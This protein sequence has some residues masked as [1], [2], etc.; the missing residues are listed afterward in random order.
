MQATTKTKM[1]AEPKQLKPVADAHRK[2]QLDFTIKYIECDLADKRVECK[3]LVH[4]FFS[5]QFVRDEE[6]GGIVVIRLNEDKLNTQYTGSMIATLGRKYDGIPPRSGIAINT[7]ALHRNDSGHACTVNVGTAHIFME[8]VLNDVERQGFYDHNHDLV[9]RTVV[10]A[11]LEPVKKGAIEFRINA[12]TVGRELQSV[13]SGTT[14][15]KRSAIASV[16]QVQTIAANLESYIQSTIETE[17]RIPD[18][19]SNMQRVRVPMELSEVSSEFTKGSFLPAAA[20]A[21]IE[22]G[23]ANAAYYRNAFEIVQARRNLT[24]ANYHDFTLEEKARTLGLMIGG[25]IGVLDYIGDAVELGSR[26]DRLYRRQHVGTDEFSKAL[27]WTLCGDCE[28]SAN[29]TASG[30]KTFIGVGDFDPELDAPLLEMQ[31]LVRDHYMAVQ[32]LAVVHGQKIGDQEGFG[33]HMVTLL[34]PNDYVDKGLANTSAGRQFLQRREP[35]SFVSAASAVSTIDKQ[36]LPLLV[37]EG[38]GILDPIGH[39]G[40]YPLLEQYR[41]VMSHMP[42]LRTGKCEIPRIEG[43]P[44]SFY[45]SFMNGIT[46]KYIDEGV[47]VGALVLGKA[48]PHYN[49]RD[50]ENAHEMVRGALFTDVIHAKEDFAVMPMPVIPDST[51]A[52]IEEAIA[53]ACPPKPLVLDKSKPMAGAGPHPVWDKFVNTVASFNRPKGNKAK[54]SLNFYFRPNHYNE[55]FIQRLVAEVA[56]APDVWAA[57]YAVEN[58]TNSMYNIRLQLYVH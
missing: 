39:A 52:I 24:V 14:V 10:V 5:N 32:T 12:V 54:G 9:M 15:A 21:M 40:S 33:A 41:Y 28:D 22:P 18:S 43:Q 27:M 47:N 6:T 37:C 42:S 31:Q 49:P 57:D 13:Q 58:W 30:V 8:D 35:P 26:N 25:P 36:Q 11:G 45:Y 55:A 1:Y 44:S 48:N 56:Q 50:P 29:A 20:F 23:K 51:M 4:M 34:L 16:L 2:V 53:F 17:M 19:V 38:T 46:D 7:Y 3:P